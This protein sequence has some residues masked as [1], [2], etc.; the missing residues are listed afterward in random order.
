MFYSVS[1][2]FWL[3]FHPISIIAIL[4][5]ISLIFLLLNFKITGSVV[6][7][8]ALVSLFI[9][10]YTNLG[11]QLLR[12]LEE[13]FPKSA[14]LP[15]KI[16]GIIVLGGFIINDISENRQITE[17]NSAADRIVEGIRLARLYPQAKL[18]ISGEGGVYSKGNS[19]ETPIKNLLS[20]L[21]FHSE[22][23]I[24]ENE[25][26]NTVENAL[27][28][29]KA[30]DI[31]ADENWLL[32]TSAYHMPR[33]MGVFRNAGINVYAAP[34]DYK[35]LSSGSFGLSSSSPDDTMSRL[36]AAMREWIGLLA[37]YWTGKTNE[38]F[39]QP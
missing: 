22:N 36:S 27:M 25:S 19:E 30:A 11:S 6:L 16:D 12:P 28:S 33:S 5:I 37:Y 24:L 29:K 20:S 7:A 34:T 17:L 4:L 26:R 9:G 15:E 14:A 10:A 13:R 35:T 8:I 18:V 21:G 1:K 38:I 23:L 31:Q 39:P 32:V 2:I 3:M